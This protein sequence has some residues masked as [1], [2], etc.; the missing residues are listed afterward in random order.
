MVVGSR[1][2]QGGGTGD[3]DSKRLRLSKLGTRFSRILVPE[4]I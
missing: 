3:W 2:V 1:Y 4:T